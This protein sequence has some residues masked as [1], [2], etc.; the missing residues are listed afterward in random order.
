MCKWYSVRGDGSMNRGRFAIYL[1]IV[2]VVIELFLGFGEETCYPETTNCQ[3][4]SDL[5]SFEVVAIPAAFVLAVYFITT[6]IL[7]GAFN[8]RAEVKEKLT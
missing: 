7:P 1:L 8:S 2:Y 5:Y 6:R 3:G 4:Y